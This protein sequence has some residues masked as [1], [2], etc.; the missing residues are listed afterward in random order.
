LGDI[1]NTIT[2]LVIGYPDIHWIFRY[3]YNEVMFEFDDEFFK[4][5]LG[6]ISL[7]EPTVISF[8]RDHLREGIAGVQND[9]LA[10]K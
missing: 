4:S 1:V 3:E 8:L 9:V 7:S 10:I 2:I 5:E 6:D